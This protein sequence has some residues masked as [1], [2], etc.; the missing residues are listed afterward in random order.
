MTGKKGVKD[1]KN[2]SGNFLDDDELDEVVGGYDSV[3]EIMPDSSGQ[4]MQPWYLSSRDSASGIVVESGSSCNTLVA[5]A[6]EFQGDTLE[7]AYGTWSSDMGQGQSVSLSDLV[8]EARM[9]S[10]LR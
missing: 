10:K 1:L 3:V 9:Y 2:V 7:G 8:T 6:K 5:R 4:G